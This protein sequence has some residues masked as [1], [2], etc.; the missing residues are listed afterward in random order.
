MLEGLKVILWKDELANIDLT[1]DLLQATLVGE[2]V[3]ILIQ[4]LGKGCIKIE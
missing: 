2:H 3:K 4:L 1:T